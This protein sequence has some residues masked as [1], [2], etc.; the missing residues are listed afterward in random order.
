MFLASDM[1]F[2]LLMPQPVAER[3]GFTCR[4]LVDKTAQSENDID[5]KQI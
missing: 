1:F 5:I 3:Q 4:N 2:S